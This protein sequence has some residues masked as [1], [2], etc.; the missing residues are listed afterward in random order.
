MEWSDADD[1]TILQLGKEVVKEKYG[2][3]FDMYQT[4]YWRKSIRSADENLSSGTLY[5]GRLMGRL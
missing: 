4:N 3:L 1:A 5:H 2:N